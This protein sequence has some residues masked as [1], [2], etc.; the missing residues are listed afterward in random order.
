MSQKNDLQNKKKMVQTNSLNFLTDENGQGMVEYGLILGLV[1]L[2]CLMSITSLGS[3]IY[4]LFFKDLKN[5]I[6]TNT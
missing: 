3:S 5:N 2:I 6:N 4:T 1:A